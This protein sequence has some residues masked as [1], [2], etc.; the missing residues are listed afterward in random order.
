MLFHGG[1][2]TEKLNKVRV[3]STHYAVARPEAGQVLRKEPH[4]TRMLL[5]AVAVL[6]VLLLGTHEQESRGCVP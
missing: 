2:K 5:R 3:I 1:V 6:A 4:S